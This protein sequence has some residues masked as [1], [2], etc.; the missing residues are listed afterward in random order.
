MAVPGG[1]TI[2]VDDLLEMLLA[3]EQECASPAPADGGADDDADL[4]DVATE[5]APQVRYP[6]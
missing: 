4:S 5:Y 6:G 1:G 3:G 2:L